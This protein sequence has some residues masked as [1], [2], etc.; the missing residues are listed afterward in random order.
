MQLVIMYL[1][2]AAI[3]IAGSTKSPLARLTVS[4][5]TKGH[6]SNQDLTYL[7]NKYPDH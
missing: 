7:S 3:M 5:R 1:S 4:T 6:S 2:V